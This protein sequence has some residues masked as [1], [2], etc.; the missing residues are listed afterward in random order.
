MVGAGAGI[1]GNGGNGGDANS[2]YLLPDNGTD[3]SEEQKLAR[4]GK[5][6]SSW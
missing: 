3:L 5:S 4:S 1:G 6:R 2:F